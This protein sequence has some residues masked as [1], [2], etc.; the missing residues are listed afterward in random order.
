L[1]L[2]ATGIALAQVPARW[3]ICRPRHRTLDGTLDLKTEGVERSVARQNSA[4]K[5][6][7]QL[8]K[9]EFAVGMCRQFSRPARRTWCQPLTTATAYST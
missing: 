2:R 9:I 7:L 8:K 1:K 5:A 3:K 6:H 4:A